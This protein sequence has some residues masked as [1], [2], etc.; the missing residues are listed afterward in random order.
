MRHAI[1]A[2]ALCGAAALTVGA[3]TLSFVNLPFVEGTLFVAVCEGEK[4]LDGKIAEVK[5]DAVEVEIDLSAYEGKRLG[6]KAF[7]DLNGNG[8]IDFDD[9]GRP[10]EPCL[11]GEITVDSATQRHEF[12]LRQ[13]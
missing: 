4:M 3:E 13:Y 11:L 2:G 1:L 8:D 6:I 5:S 10:V 12:E 9:Y 7:Q